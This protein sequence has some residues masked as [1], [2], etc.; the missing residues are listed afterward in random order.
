VAKKGPYIGH[1][2]LNAQRKVKEDVVDF[3]SLD[4]RDHGGIGA[5]IKRCGGLR[6]KVH[7]CNLPNDINIV[8]VNQFLNF[9]IL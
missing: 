9:I 2:D 6:D 7:A 5:L 8:S 1:D 4:S 3:L